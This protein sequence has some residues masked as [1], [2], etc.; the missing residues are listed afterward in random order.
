MGLLWSVS[1]FAQNANRTEELDVDRLYSI[2]KD[3]SE[4]TI[5]T[6]NREIIAHILISYNKQNR[7]CRIIMYGEAVPDM[8]NSLDELKDELCDA[9]V[10][11]GYKKIQK[12]ATVNF[13]QSGM[14][15]NNV[16]VTLYQKDTQYAKYGIK[17]MQDRN[18]LVA[19]EGRPGLIAISFISKWAIMPARQFPPVANLIFKSQ[20]CCFPLHHSLSLIAQYLL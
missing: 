16:S 7:P 13:D 9:K 15:E 1:I 18:E 11:A 19:D 4:I 2:Y 20:V 5:N 6:G 17:K 14:Y 3:K 8:Q 10:K 12:A